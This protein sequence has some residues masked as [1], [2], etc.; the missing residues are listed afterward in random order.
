MSRPIVFVL[1]IVAIILLWYISLE[2]VVTQS[3]KI[4]NDI[5]SISFCKDYVFENLFYYNSQN[6]RVELCDGLF[7]YAHAYVALQL[8]ER[9]SNKSSKSDYNWLKDIV[10]GDAAKQLKNTIEAIQTQ[11]IQVNDKYHQSVSLHK[12]YQIYPIIV[13]DND[14]VNDYK[15]SIDV[16]EYEANIFNL[17]DYKAMMEALVLPYDILYYLQERLKWVNKKNLPNIVIGDCQS[18]TI[19]ATINNEEDFANFFLHLIYYGEVN[20]QDDARYLHAII[21][22]FYEKQY[23]KNPKYKQILEIL[24][25]IKPNIASEFINR[26]DYAREKAYADH[27]DFTKCIQLFLDDKKIDIVFFSVGR[28]HLKTTKIYK[29]I[30]D[31]KQLQHKVDA[32]LIIA[33]I[34]EKKDSWV[35]DW[36]YYEKPYQAEDKRLKC[37]ENFGMYN[38]SINRKLLEEL[39][40]IIG[41]K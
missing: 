30:C 27:C 28:E 5:G 38:G 7:E 18:H 13:F 23:K 9:S 26:F 39:S 37:Y 8:K 34:S 22:K 32:V 14:N 10:Y 19:Y 16:G 36:I 25:F 12:E 1:I 21:S 4:C 17:N 31:A 3:E 29:I 2:V 35:N 11:D 41:D 15:R 20:K 24:Q 40:K 33:F 6:N